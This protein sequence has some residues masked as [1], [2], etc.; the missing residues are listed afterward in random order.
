MSGIANVGT[1]IVSVGWDDTIRFA[2]LTTGVYSDSS[3][4]IGQPVAVAASSTGLVA[5]VTTA[6]IALYRLVKWVCLVGD[7]VD[8]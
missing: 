3:A 2:D 7:M 4:T 5:V 6:E 1:E 8:A